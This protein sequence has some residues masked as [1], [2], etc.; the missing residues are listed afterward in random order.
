MLSGGTVSLCFLLCG[1]VFI[2]FLCVFADRFGVIW[3]SLYRSL[4][5]PIHNLFNL[6]SF[7]F[8]K[9]MPSVPGVLLGRGSVRLCS[10]FFIVCFWIVSFAY[11]L[12][13]CFLSLSNGFLFRFGFA[14][15]WFCSIS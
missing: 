6:K 9:T 1:P 2:G 3:L 12:W 13:T 14:F 11:L 5:G 15:D 8:I 10:V 4:V 7:Y